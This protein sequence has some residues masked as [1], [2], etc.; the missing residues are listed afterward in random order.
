MFQ[1]T[2]NIYPGFGIPGE[3][4]TNGPYRSQSYIL[5]SVSATYNVFGRAF[6]IQGPAS[7]GECNIAQ[8]GS[9]GTY[10]FAGFLVDPKM[11]VLS[12]TTA[13]PLVPTLVLAN[14]IQ[15]DLMTMGTIIVT[16]PAAANLGDWV[17][18]DNTTGA[19]STVAP[20]TTPGAGK[21]LTNAFVDYKPVSGAGLAVITASSPYTFVVAP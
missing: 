1:Q 3:L 5:E 17:V 2:V 14:G 4:F 19:L 12:G 8:A 21:S 7:T 11:Q 13:G 18:Y 9:G 10:G 15:A 6:T 16:L 20:N